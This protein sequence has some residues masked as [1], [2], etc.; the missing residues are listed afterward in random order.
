MD[1]Y[2]KVVAFLILL[3]QEQS[4][5]VWARETARAEDFPLLTVEKQ[6]NRQFDVHL[7]SPNYET[8]I[9]PVIPHRLDSLIGVKR[10]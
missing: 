1:V 6:R 5:K 10:D 9:N 7:D 3:F 8:Q 2:E 4:Q